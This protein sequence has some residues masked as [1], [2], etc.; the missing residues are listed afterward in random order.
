VTLLYQP[1]FR[2]SGGTAFIPFGSPIPSVSVA[3]TGLSSTTNYD[4]QVVASNSFGSAP[5]TVVTAS[6]TTPSGVP[7]PGSVGGSVT[8]GAANP[9]PVV[10][11]P[12]NGTVLKSGTLAV[13][14]VTFSDD[15][16]SIT[17]GVGSF[18]DPAGHTYTITTNNNTFAVDGTEIPTGKGTSAA[19]YYNGKVYAQDG[20]KFNAVPATGS[21]VLSLFDS[22]KGTKVISGQFI[23]EGPLDPVTKIQADTGEWLGLIGGDYW[24]YGSSTTAAGYTQFNAIAKS[25]WTA[26][27]L[28][29]LNHHWSNPTSGGSVGDTT[30]TGADILKAGTATND[31]F[32]AMLDS[33]ATGLADLQA[34]RVKRK[35][36]LVG[37]RNC[38]RRSI[39]RH[40]AVSSRLF[41]QHQGSNEPAVGVFCECWAE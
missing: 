34:S 18:K 11:G 37:N 28:I 7:P 19:E 3:I 12:F 32:K 33:V 13:S 35:L 14:G 25:Y 27:G 31:R 23:E 41:R 8:S 15:S 1:Q 26:G 29:A 30:V 38:L 16:F 20:T 36:V 22:I 6:T 10:S 40:V 39:C 24:H 21:S 5:S 17:P 2:V 4:F 9:K